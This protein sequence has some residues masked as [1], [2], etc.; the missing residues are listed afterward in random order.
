MV[1]SKVQ[2]VF[3]TILLLHARVYPLAKQPKHTFIIWVYLSASNLTEWLVMKNMTSQSYSFCVAGVMLCCLPWKSCIDKD[4]VAAT[5]QLLTAG[6]HKSNPY[7][8]FHLYGPYAQRFVVL[9][10]SSQSILF[11]TSCVCTDKIL[12]TFYREFV[13]S[14]KPFQTWHNC[15]NC[16][17]ITKYPPQ[18]DGQQ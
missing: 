8:P 10:L 17:E 14:W 16:L 2:T 15:S 13:F 6:V 12:Q 3:T 11:Q 4:A 5:S 1:W 9:V 18:I 7:N